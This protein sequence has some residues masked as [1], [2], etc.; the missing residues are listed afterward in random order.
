MRVAD[1]SLYKKR[2][3][4]FDYDVI[5]HVFSS[6]QSPGNEQVHRFSSHS[7][8]EQGS[9]NVI[10]LKDPAIDTLLERFLK[11]DNKQDFIGAVRALDRILLHGHYVIPNWHNDH[12]RVAFKKQVKYPAVLPLYYPIPQNWIFETGWLEP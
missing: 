1:V 6:S 8:D 12:H 2:L 9:D 4:S 10:G 7:A 11:V 3:D 5:T